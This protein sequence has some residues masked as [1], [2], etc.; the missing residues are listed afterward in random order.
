MK[1]ILTLFISC[2]F[3]QVCI[4]QSDSISSNG[5]YIP[6]NIEEC[7]KQ[8][9]IVLEKKAKNI[10]KLANERHL[11]SV[12][13]LF[14]IG[15]WLENDSTRLANYFQQFSLTS[16]DWWE[17][18]FLIVQ[19]Y[20][21]FLNNKSFDIS[22]EA[23]RLT[24][25]R[26]SIEAEKR[27]KY[28]Q[29]IIADSI[30]GVFI[31]TDLNACFKELNHL[32]I[33]SLKQEIKSK[34]DLDLSEYHMGLGRWMRNNWG[35]WGGSRLQLYFK[36]KKVF[37]PDDMSGII[38]E[39]YSKYLNDERFDTDEIIDQLRTEYG[40]FMKEMIEFQPP[41]G[42]NP[43][44]WYSKEYKRFLRTRKIKDIDIESPASVGYAY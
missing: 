34:S 33:D 17:R 41:V 43:S 7:N 20:H 42:F 18:D 32:L 28:Q 23:K 24:N 4:G 11:K 2:I 3:I 10:L 22:F 8:L 5:F 14:I 26:D 40:K 27:Q 1:V 31:P 13:G 30:D 35:L 21:R 19:S 44:D 39:T 36:E 15:E 29:N 12:T 25:K 9:D 38:L 6:K 16:S 37:H